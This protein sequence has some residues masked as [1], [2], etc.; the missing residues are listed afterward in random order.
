MSIDPKRSGRL[1]L[2]QHPESSLPSRAEVQGIPCV[3]VRLSDCRF[4]EGIA[5]TL[6]TMEYNDQDALDKLIL[7][8]LGLGTP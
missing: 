6:F 4:V 7:K 1:P 8:A 2:S 5:H 3:S